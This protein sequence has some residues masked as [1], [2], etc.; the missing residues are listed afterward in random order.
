MTEGAICAPPQKNCSSQTNR[1]FDKFNFSKVAFAVSIIFST[2][3]ASAESIHLEGKDEYHFDEAHKTVDGIEASIQ[4]YIMNSQFT[5]SI[6]ADHSLTVNG[7]TNI[8]SI[9][10]E[11]KPS[12]HEGTYLFHVI[13]GGELT[14]IG[15]VNITAI[16]PKEQVDGIGNNVFWA[17]F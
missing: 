4:P 13:D 10:D 8:R 3:L 16:H 14:L 7:D 9:A 11:L 2:S 1:L 12:H 6:G 15:D 17:K 5:F